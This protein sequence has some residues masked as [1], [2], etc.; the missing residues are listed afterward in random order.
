MSEELLPCP[1]CGGRLE[2]IDSHGARWWQHPINEMWCPLEGSD[3][4]NKNWN[5]RHTPDVQAAI[6]VDYRA[7]ELANACI[8]QNE[9][10]AD[11]QAQLSQAQ[12]N[13]INLH[14]E[15]CRLQAAI[16]GP[17]GFASWQDAAVSERIKRVVAEARVAELEALQ[18]ESE[19][20]ASLHPEEADAEEQGDDRD[21][22]PT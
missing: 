11:L 18:A 21:E 12:A 1:F 2:M 17:E 19:P 6:G 4:D 5:T 3:F 7:D 20:A 15:I 10:C 22:T 9:L 13:E 14:A 8:K 16:E